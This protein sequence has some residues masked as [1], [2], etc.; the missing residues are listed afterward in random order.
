MRFTLNG[1][2]V[3]RPC[4][5][6]VEGGIEHIDQRML[7]GSTVIV[8]SKTLEE[9]LEAIRTLSV[10]GAP[11]IGVFAALAFA[12]GLERGSDPNDLK[13][14]I[15]SARPTA[16]DPRNAVCEVEEAFLASGPKG[17][18]SK[19]IEIMERTISQCRQI[20]ELGA[21]L[22]PDGGRV[23]T[24]CNAGALA[25]VDWGTALAPIRM[26]AR[27]GG[28]PF[29]WVSETR[30]LLQGS[31]LT[32]W[33]L[34]QER[35]RHSVIVDSSSGHLMG[36]GLVDIVIVGADRVAR[37]G[38]VA[39]KIGT[40]EKAVLARENNVP[41]YVA[42]PLSTLDADTATGADI[43]IEERAARE[44]TDMNG[45]ATAPEISPAFNPAFDMTPHRYITGYVTPMGVLDR[46]GLNEL[47]H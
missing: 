44:V 25:T 27:Q 9:Q 15:L 16:V 36:R 18:M 38:D 3:D 4:L 17:A 6:P 23:M 20:G 42:L 35:I 41:F 11:A 30:P 1:Q 34:A 14:A 37:N 21:R 19:A 2:W 32:A 29:V 24:H 39:N 47:F 12:F 43:V 31:R 46:K 10:R 22:V 45:M 8:R 7:P 13:L 33:E 40:Y 5:W 26:K 28:D